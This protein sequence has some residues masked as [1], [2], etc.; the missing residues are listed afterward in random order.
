MPNR[1]SATDSGCYDLVFADPPYRMPE[2]ELARTL[3]ALRG[4]LSDHATVVVERDARSPEPDW[5][6][7]GLVLVR[8]RAYGDTAVWW[9]E[10]NSPAS[11]R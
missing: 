5:V 2:P 1:S 8:R 7:A 11:A 10:P 4:R 9:A 6:G 3:A